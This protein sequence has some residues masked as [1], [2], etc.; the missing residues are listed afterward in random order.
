MDVLWNEPKLA[1]RVAVAGENDFVERSQ[2]RRITERSVG[3]SVGPRVARVSDRPVLERDIVLDKLLI[4]KV[5]LVRFV[6]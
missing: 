2:M 5:I 1:I 3:P 6:L 4:V